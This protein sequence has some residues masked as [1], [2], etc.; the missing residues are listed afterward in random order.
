MSANLQMNTQKVTID[1]VLRHRKVGRAKDL[2]TPLRTYIVVNFSV[3]YPWSLVEL[4]WK[5]AFMLRNKI[6][7]KSLFLS[8]SILRI[9]LYTV[10]GCMFCMLLFNF[11]NCVFLVLCMFRSGYSVYCLCVNV[12]C[13][14]PL[15]V[16]P[17]GVNKY[18]IS[19][20]Y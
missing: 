14:T 18:I 15:G 17:I 1:S 2:S 11:V 3:T 6:K 8:G 19:P 16:N 13:S 4:Y 10:Y 9:S 12:Y 20:F 7:I 5:I